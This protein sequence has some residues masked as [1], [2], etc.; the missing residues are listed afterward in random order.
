MKT[1]YDMLGVSSKLTEE[2]IKS[3][4]ESYPRNLL[5]R[6]LIIEYRSLFCP[7]GK[8][9]YDNLFVN[10][11]RQDDYPDAVS[12]IDEEG[13]KKLDLNFKDHPERD[14]IIEIREPKDDD[15]IKISDINMSDATRVESGINWYIKQP[16]NYLYQGDVII[17]RTSKDL[18]D[19]LCKIGYAKII[20]IEEALSIAQE[21][22][23][24][25]NGELGKFEKLEQSN[26]KKGSI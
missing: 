23:R 22:G 17:G 11:K 21:N 1:I 10:Y 5:T 20:T 14:T 24:H 3:I 7:L 15:S 6:E 25:L 8:E 19:F 13:N 2:E 4:V 9:E 12:F 16:D 26:S 18:A